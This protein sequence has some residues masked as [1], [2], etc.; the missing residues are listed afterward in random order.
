M[1]TLDDIATISKGA[2]PQWTRVTSDGHDAV[3]FNVYQQ[4]GGN[5]V[6]I[7]QGLKG[8]LDAFRKQLAANIRIGN[9]YDQSELIVSSVSSVRD[10]ILIGVVL[11]ALILLVFLRSFRITLIAVITVP[12]VLAATVMLLYAFHMSFNIMT[13]GGMA[14]A[15]GLIIDDT[16]VM[17][18]HIMRRHREETPQG[19]KGACRRPGAR[20]TPHGLFGIDSHNLRP[21]RLPFGRDGRL[22]QG[23][24][25]HHGPQSHHLVLRGAA[26]RALT[27]R[28]S[29]AA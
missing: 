23:P 22:L 27:G 17:V 24:F 6:S 14:A 29:S 1:V 10:A 25:P 5:T 21:P 28:S 7:A 12:A 4:P 2:M 16:V 20:K 19:G 9:W 13:L 15:V 18:E 3:L 11:A 26:R 8:T